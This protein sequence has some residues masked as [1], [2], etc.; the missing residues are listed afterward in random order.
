MRTAGGLGDAVGAHRFEVDA[1]LDGEA[2]RVRHVVLQEAEF[3]ERIAG[4]QL[5]LE[6]DQ[7]DAG[8]F[9]GDGVLDLEARDWPR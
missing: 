1:E 2:A 5:E 6:L 8:N 9:L 3:R 4:G 7:I